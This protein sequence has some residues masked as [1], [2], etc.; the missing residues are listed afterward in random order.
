MNYKFELLNNYI[1][2]NPL[3]EIEF[4]TINPE[5]V[6]ESNTFIH[7]TNDEYNEWLQLHID[8]IC[9]DDS[10]EEDTFIKDLE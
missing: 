3:V 7:F 4:I 10:D 8:N 9:N 2:E 5:E 1:K 6:M